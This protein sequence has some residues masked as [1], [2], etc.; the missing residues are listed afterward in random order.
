MAGTRCGTIRVALT[1]Q[2]RGRNDEDRVCVVPRRDVSRPSLGTLVLS[3]GPILAAAAE[4]TAGLDPVRSRR[5][6]LFVDSAAPAARACGLPVLRGV[7]PALLSEQQMVSRIG[8]C[9]RQLGPKAGLYGTAAAADDIEAVRAALG[10]ER[11]DLGLLLRHLPDDG[12]RRPPPRPRPVARPARRLPDR[13]RPLGARPARRR[14]AVDRARLRPQ[15]GNRRRSF[16]SV[17]QPYMER[18]CAD[19][20]TAPV[21]SRRQIDRENRNFQAAPER[22][23]NVPSLPVAPPTLGKT[24][25]SPA[26]EA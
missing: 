25:H 13:L 21:K 11:L 19:F 12:L 20:P 6:V 7:V 15:R 14:A 9:G 16:H 5:D 23:K 17:R 24:S 18:N 1:G 26:T 4:Y 3:S 22:S 10:L 8:T 2:T